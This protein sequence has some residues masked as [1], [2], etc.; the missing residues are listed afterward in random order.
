MH[1][2]DQE[3]SNNINGYI[4]DHKLKVHRVP[5]NTLQKRVTSNRSPRDHCI[6]NPKRER[7]PP[8]YCLWT[9]KSTMNYSRIIGG[10]GR[11]IKNPSVI[12]SSSGRV[13][14]KASRWDLIVLELAA[15]GKYFVD[16]SIGF[17]I[18]ENS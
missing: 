4:S 6:E 9:C 3:D 17:T 8:S 7:K 12:I 2:R 10:A 13:P 11:M 15:K 14:E 1:I 16:S 5:T 18:L